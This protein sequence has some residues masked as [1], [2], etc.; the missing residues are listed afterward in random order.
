MDLMDKI[1][2]I[3][4][5]DQLIRMKATGPPKKLAVRLDLSTRHTYRLIN[6]L[7]ALGFPIAYNKDKQSYYYTNEVKI[8]FEIKVEEENMVSVK[9]GGLWCAY[10]PGFYIPKK[11]QSQLGLCA[12][13]M[14]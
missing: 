10:V 13:S 7:K 2:Q 11:E 14:S 6:E 1:R 4:R 5:L 8:R 3:E 9:G 12:Y